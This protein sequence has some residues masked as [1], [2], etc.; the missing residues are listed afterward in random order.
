M[1]MLKNS[2]GDS[3]EAVRWLP[4][5]TRVLVLPSGLV[6]LQHGRDAMI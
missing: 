4:K 6:R 2:Q 5:V 1:V 3:H